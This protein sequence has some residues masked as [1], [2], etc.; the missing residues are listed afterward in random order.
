MNEQKEVIQ[1]AVKNRVLPPAGLH[2]AYCVGVIVIGTIDESY[3]GHPR[4]ALKIWLKF[5]LSDCLYT[6]DEDKGPQPFIVEQEFTL[7]MQAKSNLRK[8][9][10]GLAGGEMSDKQAKDF[11]IANLLECAMIVNLISHVSESGN[12][13][14][15]IQSL[16]PLKDS[17]TI[18]P[19]SIKP[20]LFT[21]TPPF[22][23]EAFNT[24]PVFLQDKIKSSE[25]YKTLYGSH[26]VSAKEVAQPAAT[27]LKKS[28]W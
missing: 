10:A 21:F 18:S 25:E 20:V 26:A 23:T 14:V 11:N 19:M 2:K 17:D 7:S 27:G 9:I 16:I 13:S 3:M 6:F 24:L 5:E 12:K 28:P 15:K 8:L 1:G 4:K 22:K